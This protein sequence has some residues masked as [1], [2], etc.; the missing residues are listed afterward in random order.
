MPLIIVWDVNG[1]YKALGVSPYATRR[2]LMQGY[3]AKDGQSSTYLTYVFKQ[4]LNPETRKAYDTTPLGERYLDEYFQE[5]LRRNAAKTAMERSKTGRAVTGQDILDEWGFELQ[6]EEPGGS[7]IPDFHPPRRRSRTFE[8][9]YYAWMTSGYL[10]DEEKLAEWQSILVSE[11]A[12]MGITTRIAIGVT[13]QDEE[14][15]YMIDND[16]EDRPVIYL[17][18]QAEITSEMARKALQGILEP[19]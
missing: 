5:E 4:L 19:E 1:Y 3:V 16:L 8:F 13:G 7:E 2:E 17:T 11:A 14:A 15:G 10:Q 12:Q 9:G 6:S 18:E